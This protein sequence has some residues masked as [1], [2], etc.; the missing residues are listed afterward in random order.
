[1]LYLIVSV[2]RVSS[3]P[4]GKFSFFLVFLVFPT[5]ENLFSRFPTWKKNCSQ[6]A[7]SSRETGALEYSSSQKGLRNVIHI[8]WQVPLI[9]FGLF[10]FLLKSER[11]FSFRFLSP[12]LVGR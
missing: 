6:F 3:R 12:T 11:I 8:L 2:F 5:W 7:T 1:M 9:L 10:F 4:Y